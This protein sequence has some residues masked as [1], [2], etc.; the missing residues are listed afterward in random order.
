MSYRRLS[1]A[2][3]AKCEANEKAGTL[4]PRQ[5]A[6]LRGHRGLAGAVQIARVGA[7]LMAE[8]RV[9]GDEC[10]LEYD[11]DTKNS[12]P[13]D[14][15]KELKE[16]RQLKATRDKLL[17]AG[18]RKGI[19]RRHVVVSFTLDELADC[20]GVSKRMLQRWQKAGRVDLA[21][22]A[23][24]VELLRQGDFRMEALRRERDAILGKPRL[25]AADEKRL[26]VLR[27]KIADRP[28]GTRED[29]E[30]LALIRRAAAGLKASW[31]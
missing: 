25:T 30:A 22:R 26:A 19:K 28:V 11:E 17:A 12:G 29:D 14:I 20:L 21:D 13:V 24:V 31:T 23:A 4:T 10:R 9:D 6:D 15:A 18:R 7:V 8:V 27:S 1:D 16:A 5:A 3:L 2:Y